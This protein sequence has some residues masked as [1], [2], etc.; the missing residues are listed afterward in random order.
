M[1]GITLDQATAKLDAWMAADDAV[2]SGQSYSIGGRSLTRANAAEIRSNIEFW[3]RKVARLSRGGG[4]RC[5]YGAP[6]G[7]GQGAAP[8]RQ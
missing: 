8:F 6:N 1:A 4:I 7:E 5:R 3:D 2:A